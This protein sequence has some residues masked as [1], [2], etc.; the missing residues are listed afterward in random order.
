MR[1]KSR[2]K[3]EKGAWG[4]DAGWLFSAGQWSRYRL[5]RKRS[6]YG[7]RGFQGAFEMGG[8]MP[9]QLCGERGGSKVMLQLACLI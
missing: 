4:E 7:A 8:E 1:V 3:K 9:A 2:K 6:L 5:L